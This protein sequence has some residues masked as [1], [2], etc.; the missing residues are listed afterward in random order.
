[1]LQAKIVNRGQ[2]IR[3]TRLVRLCPPSSCVSLPN[4]APVTYLNWFR[5]RQPRWSRRHFAEWSQ[6][7][8]TCWVADRISS[9]SFNLG[10]RRESR[11]SS[12]P[13]WGYVGLWESVASKEKLPSRCVSDR[14]S[15]PRESSEIAVYITQSEWRA[16]PSNPISR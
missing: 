7:H 5:V 9:G 16:H 1:M 4:Q 2:L 11:F 8:N 12:P 6:A 3:P 13:M 10:T 14:G 15:L